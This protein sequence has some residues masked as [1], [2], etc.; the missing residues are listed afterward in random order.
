MRNFL[1]IENQRC[2]IRIAYPCVV[3]V[4]HRKPAASRTKA[5]I[6][7][8]SQGKL[9]HSTQL[10]MRKN[11]TKSIRSRS[12]ARALKRAWSKTYMTCSLQIFASSVVISGLLNNT[13]PTCLLR[14]VCLRGES[15]QCPLFKILGL[16]SFALSRPQLG[17]QYFVRRRRRRRRCPGPNS[18]ELTVSDL[19]RKAAPSRARFHEKKKSGNFV[20]AC[21]VQKSDPMFWVLP[22]TYNG[23]R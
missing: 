18:P 9:S 7:W 19:D 22:L 20:C 15:T 17:R 14:F 16:Q 23:T 2:P 3:V 6:S 4:I 11:L 12:T 10:Q 8:L 5:Y 21:H 1:P 13:Q